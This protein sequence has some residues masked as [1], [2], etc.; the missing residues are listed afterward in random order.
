MPIN[1]ITWTQD[2]KY[3]LLFESE[4]LLMSSSIQVEF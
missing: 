3:Q 2:M 1:R 4:I